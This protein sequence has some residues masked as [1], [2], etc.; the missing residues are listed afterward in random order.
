MKRKSNQNN[1][2][3]SPLNNYN[4]I[5]AFLKHVYRSEYSCLYPKLEQLIVKTEE[6]NNIPSFFE[7][8]NDYIKLMDKKR[9]EDAI[10]IYIIYSL[11]VN[12]EIIIIMTFDSINSEGNIEYFDTQLEKYLTIRF[13]KNTLRVIMLMKKIKAECRQEIKDNTKYFKDIFE[14]IGYFI[15]STSPSS[16]Y[17]GFSKKNSLPLNMDVVSGSTESIFGGNGGLDTCWDVFRAWRE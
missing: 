4:C 12:P 2:I 15:V 13:N 16:I 6:T 5:S 9:C 14:F 7:V 11:G 1:L 8:E 3:G 17:N 10:I